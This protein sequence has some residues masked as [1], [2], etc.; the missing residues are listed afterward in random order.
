MMTKSQRKSPA[1]LPSG[2][3]LPLSSGRQSN[4]LVPLLHVEALIQ[5]DGYGVAMRLQLCIRCGVD[6]LAEVTHLTCA[7]QCNDC[8]EGIP[9][10][11]S[12]VWRI[13]Q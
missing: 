5:I 6:R 7:L 8:Y 13:L 1:V 10:L 2:W 3:L 11:N 12:K 4:P 9:S